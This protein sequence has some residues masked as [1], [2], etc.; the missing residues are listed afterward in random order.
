MS[1]MN[2]PHREKVRHSLE[3]FADR[4]RRRAETRR[5]ILERYLSTDLPV[6]AVRRDAPEPTFETPRT[7]DTHSRI[8]GVL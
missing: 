6:G 5:A 8:R 2:R 1:Y 7:H 3:G 4:Q